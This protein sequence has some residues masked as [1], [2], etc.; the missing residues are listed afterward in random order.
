MATGEEA[1]GGAAPALSF[2]AFE[3]TPPSPVPTFDPS[4]L[5]SRRLLLF[6][7]KG[8]VGKSTVVASL[9][10]EAARRGGRPLVVELGHRHTM[11]SIFGTSAVGYEPHPVGHG[12]HAMQLEFDGAL[13]DYMNEHVKVPR[14][15]RR[16]LAN[17]ALR[18]FF[19]AAP[20]VGEIATLNK[21]S[22]LEAEREGGR[23]RD[24]AGIRRP[25][26]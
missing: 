1:R 25:W 13:T 21:L 8:G 22:A 14:L 20:A 24:A 3:G 4:T 26:T 16:V 11:R 17:H 5:L 2:Q 19:E 7:G 15:A 10:M 6:T 23:P 12:V 9:A 18:R